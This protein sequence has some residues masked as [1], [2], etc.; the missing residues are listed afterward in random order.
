M[1]ML[2][3]ESFFSS[4]LSLDEKE[5]KT[6]RDRI[7]NQSINQSCPPSVPPIILLP[8]SMDADDDIMNSDDDKCVMIVRNDSDGETGRSCETA[9]KKRLRFARRSR[10]AISFNVIVSVV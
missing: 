3:D 10:S 9:D 8:S 4:S 7:T 6:G 1:S 5:K 2:N